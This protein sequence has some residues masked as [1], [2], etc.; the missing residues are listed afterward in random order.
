MKRFLVA[1]MWMNV[2]VAADVPGESPALTFKEAQKAIADAEARKADAEKK[3]EKQEKEQ[4]V[5]RLR[6]QQAQAVA[7]SKPADQAAQQAVEVAQAAAD[8]VSKQVV[9]TT[10]WIA[11]CSD[12]LSLAQQQAIAAQKAEGVLTLPGTL[13]SASGAFAKALNE[14]TI[15]RWFRRIF[16]SQQAYF[17]RYMSQAKKVAESGNLEAQL[18]LLTEIQALKIFA[19]TEQ[20]PQGDDVPDLNTRVGINKEVS[21]I[22]DSLNPPSS[23]GKEPKVLTPYSDNPITNSHVKNATSWGYSLPVTRAREMLNALASVGLDDAG[24]NKLRLSV[25]SKFSA[26]KQQESS[27]VPESGSSSVDSGVGSLAG[28]FI[29]EVDAAFTEPD[30]FQDA[31]DTVSGNFE[32]TIT[33]FFNGERNT[34]FVSVA[35]AAGTLMAT[36]DIDALAGLQN[37]QVCLSLLEPVTYDQLLQSALFLARA[38]GTFS[39]DLLKDPKKFVVLQKTNFYK[40]LS[41]DEQ[42]TCVSAGALLRAGGT[43]TDAL[44]KGLGQ[45]WQNYVYAQVELVGSNQDPDQKSIDAVLTLD[46][47]ANWKAV[48]TLVEKT[49]GVAVPFLI[50]PSKLVRLS[51]LKGLASKGITVQS[52]QAAI[53]QIQA[54]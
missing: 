52:V 8:T 16:S 31:L 36:K 12:Q 11:V 53:D 26:E 33:G 14:N 7:K 6:L 13:P 27:I 4:A 38:S 46:A 28:D 44:S 37:L 29:A 5:A 51:Q 41:P 32:L 20:S 23:S 17:E 1:L 34:T 49:D 10:T 21:D 9:E 39:N 30:D 47:M 22:R 48:V 15:A 35:D 19:G 42:A 40:N 24:I 25:L 18:E 3:L 45:A 2:V 50:D 43:I 54:V